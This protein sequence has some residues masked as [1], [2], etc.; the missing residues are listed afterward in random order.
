[1]VG[2]EGQLAPPPSPTK[3]PGQ[4]QGWVAVM[5]CTCPPPVL[6]SSSKQETTVMPELSQGKVNL[7]GLN[8][9]TNP[10]KYLLAFSSG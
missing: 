10:S 5:L 8:V 4:R 7:T 9:W 6:C 2:L 1:M 3:A